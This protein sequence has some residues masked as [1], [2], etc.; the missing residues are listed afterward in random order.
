MEVFVLTEEK[1]NWFGVR[2]G[3]T[4]DWWE[5]IPGEEKELPLDDL[6]VEM[7]LEMSREGLTFD[8][9][10]YIKMIDREP[11]EDYSSAHWRNRVT[12]KLLTLPLPYYREVLGMADTL[13]KA[14]YAEDTAKAVVVRAW[15]EDYHPIN[16]LLCR[17]LFRYDL[18][19]I[20]TRELLRSTLKGVR[21]RLEGRAESTVDQPVPSAQPEPR[22]IQGAKDLLDV[23]GYSPGRPSNNSPIARDPK[24]L[25]QNGNKVLS[26]DPSLKDS[27][28][29][30]ASITVPLVVSSGDGDGMFGLSS[31]A[32]A[33]SGTSQR[34]ALEG[35]S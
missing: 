26:F 21:E 35:V 3:E 18:P 34:F 28:P 31:G 6:D 16:A 20:N 2:S 32:D 11:T 8:Q 15:E 23:R 5:A 33:S 10:I 4:D 9:Y 19:I 25:W 7:S 24:E 12:S 22:E 14:G 13:I 30:F 27:Q 17:F 29:K 1:L